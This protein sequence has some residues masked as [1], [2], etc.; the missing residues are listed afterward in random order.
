MRYSVY[1]LFFCFLGFFAVADAQ[2]SALPQTEIIATITPEN[3]KANELVYVA[4]TSYGTNINTAKITWATDGKVQKSGIGEKSFTFKAGALN[5][6]TMLEIT[7]ETQEGETIEK[8]LNIKPVLVDLIWES[9]GVTPPFYRGKSLFS[10]QNKLTFIALPHIAPSGGAEIS[11]KNLVYKWKKNGSVVDS[12]SG[13]G[14]NTYTFVSSLISRPV[15]VE[16]EV[17][18]TD[19]SGFGYASSDMA[20]IEPL[21]IL[22]KKDPIY[23]LELQKI[24][25]NTLSLTDSKEIMVVGVPLFFNKTNFDRNE[26]TYKWSINGITI[27]NESYQ[28]T[29]VFRQKE[30]V[31]GTSRIGLSIENPSKILQYSTTAFNLMFNNN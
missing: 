6:S 12:A 20:P 2:L 16:V 5:T 30:G 14:K 23:G 17:T 18:T 15:K 4:L 22:Y 1:I 19:S 8:T 25:Q 7:I 21:V 11:A 31:A 9:D 24:L 3:P 26:L 28:S 27:E 13:F 10:H 29:Q